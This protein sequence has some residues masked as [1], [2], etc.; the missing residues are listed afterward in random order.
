[1]RELED[2]K[3]KST[4]DSTREP[5]SPDSETG[6]VTSLKLGVELYRDM[7]IPLAEVCQ[8][9]GR[10]K[11]PLSQLKALL[12]CHE[13]LQTHV[14]CMLLSDY[15][16]NQRADYDLND[17]LEEFLVDPD[18]LPVYFY[19]LLDHYRFSTA[20]QYV[21]ELKTELQP[22][23]SYEEWD[24][25]QKQI[26][27]S[28]PEESLESL[29][30]LIRRQFEYFSF[31]RDYD[32]LVIESH[33]D[34]T[35]TYHA[36]WISSDATFEITADPKQTFQVGH[37]YVSHNERYLPLYPLVLYKKCKR[38]GAAHLFYYQNFNQQD[39]TYVSYPHRHTI[40]LLDD[41]LITDIG[42]LLTQKKAY[43]QAI[44]WYEAILRVHPTHKTARSNLFAAHNLHGIHLYETKKY[45]E[46]G[47]QFRLALALRPDIT[48]IYHNLTLAY[49][50]SKNYTGALE[51]V[52]RLLE[53]H[54][55][56]PK[57]LETKAQILEEQGK[58]KEA[59]KIYET[60]LKSDVSYKRIFNAW[61]RLIEQGDTPKKEEK[62]EA[63]PTAKK[64][65]KKAVLEQLT[66]DLTED[67]RKTRYE[68]IYG[69]DAELDETV[70]ILS[71][72]NKNNAIL[73]GESGVGK[74]SVIQELARRIA[75]DEV[76]V[77][78][79]GKRL[80]E[81]N[82]ASLVAGT[83]FRGELEERIL[84]FVDEVK[85][86][87]DCILFFDEIHTI[88]QGGTFRG[89]S[90]EISGIL[91]PALA[92]GDIQCI[93]TA[94]LD[95]YRRNIERDPT[96]ER[97]FQ[98]VRIEEP[99]FDETLEILHVVKHRFEKFYNVKFDKQA[100]KLSVDLAQTYLR[101]R[102]LPD[103]AIDLLDRAGANVA[104][105]QDAAE[106][107]SKRVTSSDIVQLV[108]RMSGVPVNKVDQSNAERY[109]RMEQMLRRKIIG[110]SEAIDKV[111]QVIR[112]NRL[113][114]KIN[115][116][117]PEGVF[118]FLGPTGVGKT[119]L[120]RV[121]A[122]FLFGSVDDLIRIDMSEFSDR[123][124]T[125]KLVGAAPGYVG[126][127]DPN[128]L[129]DRV[130]NHPYTLILLDEIEKADPM[131]LNIFLQVF[132]AGRLT[133][134]KGRD[135]SFRHTTVIMT[136]NIGSDLFRRSSIGYGDAKDNDV[137]RSQ[138]MR[139]LQNRLSPEFL[140]RIDEIVMFNQLNR[141]D[142]KKILQLRLRLIR[143]QLRKENKVLKLYDSAVDLLI[144]RGFDSEFGARHLDKT[145]RHL[146]LDPMA[147]KKLEEGWPDAHHIRVY[148]H[149]DR[150][151]FSLT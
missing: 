39:I 111:S 138:L 6:D 72:R 150:L 114:L 52:N 10:K 130:R 60:A 127:N 96:L 112:T 97:R 109:H 79:Q 91:K 92:K 128:Q 108:S 57:A 28:H 56:L 132:D 115:P 37:C 33:D 64:E 83:K 67:A 95:D 19:L 35:D 45:R 46:S 5:Y 47:E 82:T 149:G 107:G 32:L 36:R 59:V 16:Q 38:C 41:Q 119:E 75:N 25:A 61:R 85:K 8:S 77:S 26:D 105:L 9:Y 124:A 110:Q 99:S 48:Q 137:S 103:K 62:K 136:S 3:G 49:R 44:Q 145:I 147:M 42:N 116:H 121:L 13:A 54:P 1:M 51:V 7:P 142:M 84:T 94:T 11:K 12:R 143:D 73:V 144:D 70:E 43:S 34:A 31:I 106:S 40:R 139:E 17:L 68:P 50:K 133:D 18:I 27:F 141:D 131:V 122:E 69:R 104:L 15:F 14:S 148:R 22:P 100:L 89:S 125:T 123:I 120:A 55:N 65:E 76:P 21:A 98:V 74:S 129:T 86:A 90:I 102:C 88:V 101:D 30:P 66:L 117:R 29:L 4:T 63:A 151:H 134:A 53:R 93:G 2:L 135:V 71:C 80:L 126:Y 23:V 118:L 146:L 140:G 81:L 24:L 78:L 58:L 87:G 20:C 113:A